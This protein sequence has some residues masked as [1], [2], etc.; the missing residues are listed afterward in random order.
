MGNTAEVRRLIEARIRSGQLPP[1]GT[2]E[3]FGRRGDGVL[4]ACCDLPIERTQLEYD[5]EILSDL[6]PQT[7][8]AMHVYCYHAWHQVSLLW[9]RK[10][11]S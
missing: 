8:L 6:G 2:H 10:A 9:P 1:A 7:T 4:C 5:V 11:I 3:T